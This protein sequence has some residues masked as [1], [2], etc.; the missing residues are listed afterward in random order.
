MFLL[1]SESLSDIAG[2]KEKTSI[3]LTIFSVQQ[4]AHKARKLVVVPLVLVK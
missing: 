2:E 1:T 3:R 4:K